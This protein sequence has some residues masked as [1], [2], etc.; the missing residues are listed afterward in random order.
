MRWALDSEG[1]IV[2]RSRDWFDFTGLSASEARS[3][4]RFSGIHPDDVAA[5]ERIFDEAFAARAP[6]MMT[7]RLQRAG[8]G[9]VWVMAGGAPALAPVDGSFLGYFGSTEPLASAPD[10]PGVVNILAEPVQAAP[11]AKSVLML[12]SIAEHLMAARSMA[13]RNAETNVVKTLD[14]VL[15][16]VGDLIYKA[17]K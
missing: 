4:T 7:L 14:L 1:A 5:A 11:P 3:M 12:D 9:Y 2:H 10:T 17:L 15:I 16:L 6:F 8:S 13:K